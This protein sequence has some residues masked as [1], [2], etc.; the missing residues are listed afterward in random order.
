MYGG[1]FPTF[2]GRESQD[3]LFA[4][5]VSHNERREVRSRESIEEVGWLLGVQFTVQIV[6]GPGGEILEVLAGQPSE[7]FR[8]GQAACQRAWA[9]N[10]PQS[11]KLVVA[12]IEGEAGEQTWD[13]VARAL[14]AA[15]RVV[16]PDG[17]IALCTALVDPP[18]EVLRQSAEMQDEREA[19]RV[20]APAAVGRCA[21]GRG[22]LP[23]SCA[24]PAVHAQPAGRRVGR[25]AKHHA[26]GQ[27]DR[28][29][30]LARQHASCILLANAQYAVP[31]VAGE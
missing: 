23:G 19:L 15:S 5:G 30:R 20:R 18:G 16:S 8:R 27:P 31:T 1:L 12:A 14:D 26:A 13:N 25:R 2:S 21:A 28:T 3:K 10:V 7:V 6:P 9:F 17:A 24:S 4:R 11:A 22:A 29:G